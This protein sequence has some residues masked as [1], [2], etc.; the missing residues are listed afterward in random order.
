[1]ESTNE[2]ERM[3]GGRHQ[4]KWGGHRGRGDKEPKSRMDPGEGFQKI[5]VPTSQGSV[6]FI[7][8]M[9]LGLNP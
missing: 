1:M 8:R 4:G 3:S 9:V 7:K 5:N 6:Q 2:D